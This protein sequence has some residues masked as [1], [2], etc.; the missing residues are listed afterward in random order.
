MRVCEWWRIGRRCTSSINCIQLNTKERPRAHSFALFS[1]M[2]WWAKRKQRIVLADNAWRWHDI[3]WILVHLFVQP[4]VEKGTGGQDRGSG[5]CSVNGRA[6]TPPFFIIRLAPIVVADCQPHHC[7]AHLA[8]LHPQALT[9]KR[10]N[11][12]HH[13]SVALFFSFSFSFLA[14]HLFFYF[15]PNQLRCCYQSPA[16]EQDFSLTLYTFQGTLGRQS[17]DTR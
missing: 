4:M 1:G 14:S 3:D 8:L 17:K 6:P 7:D 16:I 12:L 2:G 15:S 11:A 5:E 10:T 9:H 13:P